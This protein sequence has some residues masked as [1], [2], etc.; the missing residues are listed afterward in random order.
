MSILYDYLNILEKKRSKEPVAIAPQ[1]PVQQ[2]KNLALPPSFAMGILFLI[3]AVLFVTIFKNIKSFI[4]KAAEKVISALQ[5]PKPAVQGSG[6][7]SI[8]RPVDRLSLDY[9]L[10]GITPFLRLS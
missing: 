1:A 3:I 2:K 6:S 10:K 7:P 4:P 5:S 8:D 9:S